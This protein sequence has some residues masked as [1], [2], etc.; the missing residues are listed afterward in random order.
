MTM[1]EIAVSLYSGSMAIPGSHHGSDPRHV[2]EAV[3]VCFKIA[4]EILK[5]NEQLE[6][7]IS[8]ATGES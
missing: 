7:E 3:K 5:H 8:K 4:K 2:D 6:K 1:L